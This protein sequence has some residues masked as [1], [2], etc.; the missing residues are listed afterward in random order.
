ML[1]LLTYVVYHA[2]AL[3]IVSHQ[4]SVSQVEVENVTT[5]VCLC[6]IDESILKGIK[7]KIVALSDFNNLL[8]ELTDSLSRNH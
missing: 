3:A 5:L 2:D 6:H 1:S 8:K 7:F 4:N